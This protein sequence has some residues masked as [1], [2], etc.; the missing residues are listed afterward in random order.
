MKSSKASWC[1]HNIIIKAKSQ[2]I[3]NNK[4]NGCLL[5]SNNKENATNLTK[6]FARLESVWLEFPDVKRFE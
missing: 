6:S 5:R 1:F 3:N 4:N 2:E